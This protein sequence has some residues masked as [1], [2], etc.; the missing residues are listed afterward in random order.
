ML[1][2]E[3]DFSKEYSFCIFNTTISTSVRLGDGAIF[4]AEEEAA[5]WWVGAIGVAVFMGFG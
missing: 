1:M 5:I 3:Y 2:W 4:V